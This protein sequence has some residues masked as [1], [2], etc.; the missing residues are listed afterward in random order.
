M[1]WWLFRSHCLFHILNMV[2]FFEVTTSIPCLN[3]KKKVVRTITNSAHIAHSEPILK[4]L[5]LLKVQHL[6]ELKTLQ[7]LYKLYANDYPRYFDVYHLR[8]NKIETP[9]ALHSHPLPV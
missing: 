7:F 6:H 1:F 3:C 4:G 9:Y 8:L 2:L 5:S